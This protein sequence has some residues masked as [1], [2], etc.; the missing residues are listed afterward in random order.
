MRRHKLVFQG[1]AAIVALLG[2]AHAATQDDYV[3]SAWNVDRVV[4]IVAPTG[5]PAVCEVVYKKPDENVADKVLWRSAN[6]RAFCQGK[7]EA[8]VHRLSAAGFKC[9]PGELTGSSNPPR[10]PDTTA[11]T[12]AGLENRIDALE[13]QVGDT[14]KELSEVKSDMK[15]TGGTVATINPAPISDPLIK[16]YIHGAVAADFIASDAKGSNSSFVGGKFLPIFLAQYSDWLLF[17]GHMEFT[18][19]SEGDTETSLEY[20]QLDFLVND[21]LTI[22]AGKFLSPIGQ[23]QQAVHPPWINKLPD[24]PP[25][26]VEDGGDEPLTDVGIMARGGFPI[27]RLKGTYAVYVGNGPRMSDAGPALEGFADDD[28]K[29]KAVGGRVSLFLLPH[30]EIGASGMRARISG[31]EAMAGTAT[32]ADY[33]L[34]GADFAFTQGNWDIRGEWIKSHLD[35]IMS[36][37]DPSDESPTA[38]PATT[39]RNWYVQA[40]YRMAGVT[41]NS[42]LEK[43]EP[44]I[45]YSQFHIKGFDGFGEGAEDRFSA[46]LA[47]WLAPSI[48]AKAAYENRHHLDGP[49]NNVFHAQVALGF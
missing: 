9:S 25:G 5:E 43:V 13:Q 31:M 49:T 40:A 27:G 16:F 42:I 35:S 8:L 41:D 34:I 24:R 2:V 48:V 26:F 28:N 21:H 1:S 29:D 46:G 15:T 12:T 32:Q 23:F 39:W 10:K 4:Q 3:C 17:E 30:L 37:L 19:T 38:I 14:R 20:A 47:Y 11:D 18:S 44:V 36:A 33:H 22:V 7:A 6:S 45:R